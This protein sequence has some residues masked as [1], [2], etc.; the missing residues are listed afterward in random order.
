[1]YHA[2]C[3]CT[4]AHPHRPTDPTMAMAN[5]NAVQIVRVTDGTSVFIIAVRYRC[6]CVIVNRDFWPTYGGLR[7]YHATQSCSRTWVVAPTLSEGT[8]SRQEA[9]VATRRFFAIATARTGQ[10]ALA[11]SGKADI[12]T[13]SKNAK[14]KPSQNVECRRRCRQPP[15]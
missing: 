8:G 7:P 1:M 11:A 3:W 13:K 2:F 4:S 14:R 9:A 10:R 5:G 12:Q 15:L 6:F